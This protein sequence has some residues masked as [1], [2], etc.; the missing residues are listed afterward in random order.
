MKIYPLVIE[1]KVCLDLQREALVIKPE[2][3]I[4]NNGAPSY[5]KGALGLRRRSIILKRGP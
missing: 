3:P 4:Y 1:T 2:N 5:K